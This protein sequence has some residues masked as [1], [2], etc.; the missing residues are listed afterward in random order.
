MDKERFLKFLSRMVTMKE[1]IKLNDPEKYHELEK[2]DRYWT[3]E[4]RPAKYSEWVIKNY[5][6]NSDDALTLCIYS[7]LMNVPIK[8]L[9][10]KMNDDY[11]PVIKR[12]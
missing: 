12:R 10:E 9:K 7:L 1:I 3:P 2:Q 8:D 6:F 5:E 11:E 4:T